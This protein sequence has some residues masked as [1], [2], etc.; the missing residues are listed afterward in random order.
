MQHAK[1]VLL[2]AALVSACVDPPAALAAPAT[3]TKISL[4]RA[5][6]LALR[7]VPGGV[8]EQIERDHH[9][10][11][12]VYEIDVRAPDGREHEL[13]IDA[14]DGAILVEEIDVD[15]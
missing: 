10:G 6:H 11:K 1:P 15:D 5:E 4:A 7:H 9:R 2:L 3:P 12:P 13:V 8:V 14:T